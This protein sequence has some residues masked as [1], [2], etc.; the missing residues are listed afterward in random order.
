VPGGGQRRR[1][2]RRRR[3]RSGQS[4]RLLEPVLLYLLHTGASHGYGLLDPLDEFGLGD[5]NP[6]VVY[7]ALR[8]MEEQG[9]VRSVWEGEETQGPPRRNYEL[10]QHGDDVLALWVKDLQEVK[11][12]IGGLINSYRGRL[13]GE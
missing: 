12:Q 8:E 5:L 11:D 3:G 1:R 10:T 6:S 9:W 4:I 13:E 7:R 2:A